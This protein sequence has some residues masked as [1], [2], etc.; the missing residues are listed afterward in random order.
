[1]AL[2]DKGVAQYFSFLSRLLGIAGV[3]YTEELTSQLINN[4]EALV[5]ILNE[6]GRIV[7]F[8]PACERLSGYKQQEVLGKRYEMLMP[9]EEVE[10]VAQGVS[11]VF[12]DKRTW[13][14][15][16]QWLTK[17]GKRRLIACSKSCFTEKNG[18]TRY[19]LA[20]GL[21]VTEA[22][23]Q[24]KRRSLSLE[25]FAAIGSTSNHDEALERVLELLREYFQCDAAGIRLR[26]GGDYPYIKTSGFPAGFVSEDTLLCSSRSNGQSSLAEESAALECICGRVI[27]G[28]LDLY[29]SPAT[30][31][32]AFLMS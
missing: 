25:I 22:R 16:I 29:L 32:G 23:L 13:Q 2:G 6:D 7:A 18:F 17:E 3:T 30:G 31:Q 21:D 24:E 8:N 10:R 26:K 1:M 28:D 14:E 20:T 4:V 12:S 9:A 27:C 11:F 19:L 15:E 5:F